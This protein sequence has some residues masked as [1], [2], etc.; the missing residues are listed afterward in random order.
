MRKLKRANEIIFS[1]AKK[2]K[3]ISPITKEDFPLFESFFAKEA[4]T[5]GNSWTYV[6][7]G[8]YGIG[9]NNLGYKYY[10]GENL[11]A[12]SV[13]PKIENPDLNVFYWIRPM[14]KGILDVIDEFSKDL[15]DRDNVPTYAKKLF[16]DQ[17]KYLKKRGF[18]DVDKFPWHSTAPAEDDTYPERILDIGKTI[19]EAKNAGKTR[20]LG[21]S[22]KNYYMYKNDDEVEKA[23]VFRNEEDAFEVA[24]RFF[25]FQTKKNKPNVS[26]AY[27]F[28]NVI[29]NLEKQDI[30][31]EIV[32]KKNISVAFYFSVVQNEDYASLYAMLSDRELHNNVSDFLIFRILNRLK[33]NKLKHLNLGGSELKSLDEY[34]QKFRPSYY[35]QMYWVCKIKNS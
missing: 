17:Y 14:G 6:T 7:Q 33:S 1:L 26:N 13:Y 10:D 8:M 25:K 23:S 34:K 16:E 12:V 3:Y 28:Y 24:K 4:H 29:Y 18:Q 5:Y 11:S 15:L 30:L 19:E 20:Q 35:Q 9:K 2:N 31:E 32:Y 27:D 21:R 22:L